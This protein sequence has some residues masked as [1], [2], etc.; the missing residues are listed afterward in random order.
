MKKVHLLST[1]AA[2]LLLSVGAASAQNRD[3]AP[4]HAPAA[5]RAAPAE[6]IAPG[7]K[8]GEHKTPARMEKGA[9]NLKPGEKKPP[10]TTGQ[11]PTSGEPG[12]AMKNESLDNKD[13]P[14][15][16]GDRAESAHEMKGSASSEST[17]EQ[18]R[19]TT[20]QGAAAGAAKLSTEQRSKITT[21]FKHHRVAPAHLNISIHVGARV[22]ET[23][24]F[25]PLPV[26]VVDVYP[27][28]RGYDY[29]L[30]GD[31]ILVIDPDSH[32]IVA[33]LEA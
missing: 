16:K 11:A 25:Y 27:E 22:P 31:Q 15:R 6:K 23:V 3:E 10:E 29:I 2:A 12:H 1:V 18:H 20:G 14:L 13:E 5:Q 30:V 8:A 4:A 32:E 21:I 33:V 7:L 9:Q 26:E 19:T 24:H 28:W 17:S